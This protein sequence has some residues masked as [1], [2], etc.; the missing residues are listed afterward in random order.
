MPGGDRDP[1]EHADLV[2][3]LVAQHGVPDVEVD[4]AE[5]LPVGVGHLRA[6]RDATA[7]G[8]LAHPAHR[9]LVARVVAAGDVRAGHDPS[10]PSSS[11]TPSPRSALRSTT[12]SPDCPRALATARF[13][14]IVG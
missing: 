9:R 1:G 6:D 8:L 2:R 12:R 7:G 5:V 13:C 3:D 10:S 4:P 11:V 14:P